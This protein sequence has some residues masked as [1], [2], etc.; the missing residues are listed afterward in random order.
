VNSIYTTGSPVKFILREN[1]H[2]D[3]KDSPSD[4][5]PKLLL[6]LLRSSTYWKIAA[7]QN[8]AYNGLEQ[9][10]QLG[11]FSS[12]QQLGTAVA[13]RITRWYHP[14]LSALLIPLA[15]PI[16]SLDLKYFEGQSFQKLLF[17]KSR[18][19]QQ[20]V[21]AITILLSL[22]AC[23]SEC[24][25]ENPCFFDVSPVWRRIICIDQPLRSA[26]GELIS[27]IKATREPE[28][29]KSCQLGLLRGIKES[30]LEKAQEALVLEAVE[31]FDQEHIDDNTESI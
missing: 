23:S 29:C 18:I 26:M 13:L 3:E 7:L 12:G 27:I 9:C 25:Y 19:D 14:A 11:L 22:C 6:R 1:S 31:S 17:W 16:H 4:P 8:K 30:G 10:V 21:S 5:N 24:N 15:L 28:L 2:R 20:R